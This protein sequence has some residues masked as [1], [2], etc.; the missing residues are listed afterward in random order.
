[1][2][3]ATFGLALA[4]GATAPPAHSQQVGLV[5]KIGFL[6]FTAP[7]GGAVYP[8]VDGFRQGLRD[9]GWIEGQ[10]VTIEYRWAA[11]AAWTRCQSLRAIPFASTST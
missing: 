7:S 1:M 3:I 8:Y 11:E 10:T 6:S 9:S 2:G 5:R 4:L